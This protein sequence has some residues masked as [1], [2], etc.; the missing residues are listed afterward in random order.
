M[1]RAEYNRHSRARMAETAK[2]ASKHAAPDAPERIDHRRRCTR[3]DHRTCWRGSRGSASLPCHTLQKRVEMCHAGSRRR[4]ILNATMSP[5]YA[6]RYTRAFFAE[7]ESIR[8]HSGSNPWGGT[9][10]MTN[11]LRSVR[12]PARTAVNDYGASLLRNRSIY[13]VMGP[14]VSPAG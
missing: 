10:A 8:P 4:P 1:E 2:E 14:F 3:L 13:M 6:R 12:V 7:M 5:L 9:C 11:P